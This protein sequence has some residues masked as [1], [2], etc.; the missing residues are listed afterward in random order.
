MDVSPLPHKAPYFVAQITLPSPSP[1]ETPEEESLI[2]PD[3]L[4]PI[5]IET[6]SLQPNKNP[7]FLAL[8]EYVAVPLYNAGLLTSISRRRRPVTRPSFTRSNKSSTQIPQHRPTSSAETTLPPFRFGNVNTHGMSCASTP[9]LLESFTES[10]V[11]GMGTPTQ[12]SVL[13]LPRRP[14]LGAANRASGSPCS[15]HVRK[16]SGGR[17]TFVR[18]TRKLIRRSLSMFQHPDDVMKEEQDNFDAQPAL[19]PL[20]DID[21][22][23]TLKL[24]NFV[25][26]NEPDGLPRITQETLLDV[27]DDK[28]REHYDHVKI[29]DCRFEY[30]YEGGHI[31][32]AINFNDKQLLRS[33]LF[34]KPSSASTLLIFHCEYSVHRA[35]LTAKHIRG[36]DRNVNAANYPAL[37]YPE[38]YILDGGY[39]KF[40][41]NHRSKCF[42]QNYVEMNDQRHEQDCERGM[43]K[44]KQRQ[45]LI[46]AQTFA[47]GQNDIDDSPTAAGRTM[48]P[49]SHSTFAV[50]A[51]LSEGIGQ[52]FQ[53][54]M[55]SY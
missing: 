38:M 24:P 29:I 7:T 4:S 44:V 35:P 27:L 52:S 13:P 21:Q 8:P 31:E 26:E 39:S 12:A 17:P 32:G 34:D 46:R 11:D 36:E 5:E 47:F 23:P 9:S 14:S 22:E 19:S 3:L 55:A 51:A 43:A 50:G 37:T 2:S 49:R 18:P 41:Q 53:R 54:R 6:Q 20:M 33:E 45:K 1:E 48:G 30:E 40:F 25:S 16:P 15:G 28:Y 42:P 10:P